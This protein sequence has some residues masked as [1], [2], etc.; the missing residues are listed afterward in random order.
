MP[1]KYFPHM[2]TPLKIKRTVFKNRVFAS[3]V[4]ANRIV[5]H[6]YPTPEGIDAYET[7]ARGGFAQVTLTESFVDNEFASRHEHGLNVYAK[8]MTTFHAES[9]E[10]LTEAIKAHG[11]V[12]SIQLNHVGAVNHPSATKDHRNPIGPS[13]FVRADG[14]Q[15]DEMDEAMMRRVADNFAYAAGNCKALGFDTVMLHGGHGWLLSQFIS[16]L[17]NHRTDGYGGSLENRARFPVMVL[18][19]VREEVGDDFLIEY[20]VSGDERVPGGMGIEE[21]VA[22]CKLIESKADIFHVTAGIYHSHVETKAFSSMFDPHGCNLDLAAA[23]KAAVNV[24][25]VA[26]GGFN[27]PEQVEEALTSG[28]CDFV[29][30][31]RQQFADPAFVNKAMAG[32]SKEIAPCLRCSCFNPLHANPDERNIEPLWHCAVN[33]WAGR[34]FRW[35]NAPRPAGKRKVLVIGGGAAGMYAAFTAAERGHDVVLAEKSGGLGGLLWFTDVDEH[36]ESLRRFRDC[37]AERCR[38]GG[39]DVRLNTEATPELIDA[40]AP[41]AVICAVG[42]RANVPPIKGID[43]AKHALDV[44]ADPEALGRRIAI[45]GGGL[46]GC[47]TGLWLAEHGHGVHIL[48][49]RNELASEAGD[50]HR[51][52]LLPRMEARGVKRSLGVAVTEIDGGGVRYKDANGA[53]CYLEA[54]T[55]VYAVGQRANAE[56]TEAL[57]DSV[58]CRFTAV[59]DCVNARQVKQATYE[60]FCAAM[61]IL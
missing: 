55:V 14:I 16:P 29:A 1:N 60:G 13:A 27:A 26:V 38:A 2:F 31:G 12:A 5:D 23:V 24:P 3:P 51:R 11:A 56:R 18:D 41:D 7:R 58:S 36:K 33:P 22:F 54:D 57:R 32:R 15:I 17:S 6:G 47:E 42:S 21:T 48:E 34:E 37:L 35:R 20:R 19:R 44:Y 52:A 50:S 9:M 4:T 49:M 61:D 59:G 8:A 10:T 43:L 40:L 28:K 45:I 25:V 46:I 30:L 39:V 53:A